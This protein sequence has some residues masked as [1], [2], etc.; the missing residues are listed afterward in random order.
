M[1][2]WQTSGKRNGITIHASFFDGDRAD[3]TRDVIERTLCFLPGVRARMLWS[4]GDRRN[5]RWN[6]VVAQ[7]D[8]VFELA[9]GLLSLEY[10]WK[11]QRSIDPTAWLPQMRLKDML[12]CL[13]ASVAVAQTH[14][15]TCAAVLRYHNVGLLL[16]PEQRLLDLV[17]GMIPAA[18]DY[19]GQPDIASSELADYAVLKVV[20]GFP[21][22]DTQRSAAGIEAHARM[23][24]SSS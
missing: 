14:G 7:S 12:Q 10:K 9:G 23:F 6:R 2:E 24:R 5:V 20:K 11:S 15:R 8:A 17:V 19:C 3:E 18:C 16:V 1:F 22:R 4:E 21:W 13:I